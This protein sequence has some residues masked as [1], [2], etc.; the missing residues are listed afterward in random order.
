MRPFCQSA[1]VKCQGYSLRLQRASSDFGADESIEKS[2]QKLKEHYGIEVPPSAIRE[3][4]L[5]HGAAMA[6]IRDSEMDSELPAGGTETVIGEMDGCFVP[7][8]T[9]KPVENDESAQDGRK[10]RELGWHEAR[11]SLGRDLKKIK[12][13]YAATMGTVEEATDLLMDCLIKAGA[14]KPT[15]LHCMGDGAPWIVNRI[16]EKF[17][18]QATFLLDFYHLSGY[19]AD[20][21]DVIASGEKRAW[22]KQQQDRLKENKVAEVLE[23][24]LAHCDSHDITKCLRRYGPNEKEQCPADRCKRYIESRLNYLDYK[25]AIKAELPIGT[26]EVESGHRSV[27]QSRIKKSGAWWRIENVQKILAL[28]TNR[29]NQQWDSYWLRLRQQAA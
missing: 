19:L 27:I 26:G 7:I 22:L 17:N 28:R 3:M 8:V 2:V 21:A 1:G 12:P 6:E 18:G 10:R 24:L 14:G 9:I 5:K 25:S 29:A 23:E 16:T 4:I 11:L 15:K 20:A 13:Q